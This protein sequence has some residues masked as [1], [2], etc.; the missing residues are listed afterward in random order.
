MSGGRLII[1]DKIQHD[2]AAHRR[3]HDLEEGYLPPSRIFIAS[4]VLVATFL[5]MDK[6]A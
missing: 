1:T 3:E 4:G 2:V 5:R 6:L